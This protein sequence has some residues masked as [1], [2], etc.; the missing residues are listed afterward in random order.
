MQQRFG[1][2][3]LFSVEKV[4]RECLWDAVTPSEACDCFRHC[5]IEVTAADKAWANGF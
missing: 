2:A 5:F 3:A 1:N 4:Y